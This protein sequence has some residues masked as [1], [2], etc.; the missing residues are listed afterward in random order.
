M[1]WPNG[2]FLHNPDL[3]KTSCTALLIT[4]DMHF[5][6]F[7]KS[8]KC[9]LDKNEFQKTLSKN[10]FRKQNTKFIF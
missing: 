8:Q 6:N 1:K 10:T 3:A 7:I 4:S 5:I 2:L 9:P